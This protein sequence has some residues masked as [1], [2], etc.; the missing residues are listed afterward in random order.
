[1]FILDDTAIAIPYNYDLKLVAASYLVAAFASFAAFRLVR[2]VQDSV[3]PKTRLGWLVTA[4]FALGTGVWSMHFI[5][6]LSIDI[7]A[8]A[9]FD[10]GLTALSM[11]F[12]VLASGAAFHMVTA[13]SQGPTTRVMLSGGLILGGGIGAMHYTGMASIRLAADIRYDPA[14]FALSIFIA[15]A[16]AS[17]ALWLLSRSLAQEA[18]VKL[19]P[20]LGLA[21]IMGL[22]ITL[23][24]YTGMAATYFIPQA[25]LFPPTTAVNPSSMATLVGLSAVFVV[26]MAMLAMISGLAEMWAI[27]SVTMASF[28]LFTMTGLSH[29]LYHSLAWKQHSATVELFPTMVVLVVALT[30]FAFRRAHEARRELAERMRAENALRKSEQRF[31]GILELAREAII[32]IDEKGFI[33]I[34]N[35]GAEEIFGY[36]SRDMLGQPLDLLIPERFRGAHRQYINHFI[37]S[38]ETSLLMN[39]RGEIC[40][41]RKGGEE[42]PAEASITKLD[43]GG[44]IILTVMLHD[45]SERKKT[46]EHLQQTQKMEALG[47]LT[48]GV[49]HEFNNLL[50]AILGNLELIDDEVTGNESVAKKLSVAMESTLRGKSLTQQLLAYS[51]TGSL[52]PELTD[53]NELIPHSCRMFNHALV[54]TITIETK[55]RPD[56]WPVMIDGGEFEGALLNLVINARDAMAGVGVITIETANKELTENDL[57]TL[58]DLTPGNYV[59]VS[60][61]DSGCGIAP[62]VIARAFDP[63]FTTKEV[64]EG[65]GLG[66]SMVLGFAKEA[67]G[68]AE[69]ESEL[70]HGATV[71]LY[72]PQAE[73]KAKPATKTAETTPDL[74]IGTETVLCVEDDPEVLM[75]GTTMLE[76]LGYTVLE[77]EDGPSGLTLLEE[78][79]HIDLLLSDV[80]MP[81]GMQGTEL[82]KKALAL[83]PHLKILLATGYNPEEIEQSANNETALPLIKKPF[84]KREL[85]FMVREILDEAA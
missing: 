15:V 81:G 48:G 41:L 80:V 12:A 69:I 23:M 29:S 74:P 79:R 2:P 82:A 73:G 36:E 65:A 85:A 62:E 9:T 24:H 17:V 22:A 61:S 83:H 55:T 59:T 64:G 38:P 58:P 54:K 84:R 47:N 25:E 32:S 28:V 52:H 39:R 20:L 35:R 72:L 3:D 6:M 68:T 7:C 5:A 4:A 60:V 18:S 40:G 57:A 71:R 11:L 1:M 43:S 56:L 19:V 34:Y 33:R 42:F 31:S 21:G 75:I 50:M 44:E 46:E 53:L 76:S 27:I 45:I 13:P 70:G 66:L 67:G 14:L 49:A 37:S 8:K 10:I 78:D 63:F 77:A 30:I 16:L 51:R 26:T